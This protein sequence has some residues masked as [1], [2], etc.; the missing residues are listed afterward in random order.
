M[1]CRNV[2]NLLARWIVALGKRQQC[3][4]GVNG[5]SEF[6]GAADKFEPLDMF[7]P[8]AAVSATG[9]RWCD[10]QVDPFVIADRLNIDAGCV[11]KPTNC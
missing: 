3:P 2:A 7:L 5:E 11:R 10:K 4:D 6:S 1:H 8:I 9:T